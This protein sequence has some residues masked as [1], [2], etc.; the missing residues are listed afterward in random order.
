MDQI[1]T[2]G[3]TLTE[4]FQKHFINTYPYMGIHASG[5]I[6]TPMEPN[7]VLHGYLLHFAADK[8]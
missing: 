2:H 7:R 3:F 5:Y 6:Y 8:D 4:M 1:Q